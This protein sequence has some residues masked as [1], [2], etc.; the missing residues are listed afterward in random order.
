MARATASSSL[1]LTSSL[2]KPS[3]TLWQKRSVV[4]EEEEGLLQRGRQ[5]TASLQLETASSETEW[6][7][8]ASEDYKPP[9]KSWRNV[10][11][12]TR[13]LSYPKLRSM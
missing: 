12:R 13:S 4:P 2:R 7:R 6:R 1:A 8:E 5:A 3:H 9:R 11:E 10:N